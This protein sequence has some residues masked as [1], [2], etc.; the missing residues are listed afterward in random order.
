MFFSLV[1]VENEKFHILSGQSLTNE[2]N[3]I[4]RGLPLRGLEVVEDNTCVAVLL[5]NTCLDHF[6][7]NFLRE[8]LVVAGIDLRLLLSLGRWL[9]ALGFLGLL[10][11]FQSNLKFFLSLLKVLGGFISNR[12]STFH[13]EVEELIQF[14]NASLMLLREQ[15]GD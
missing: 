1:E 5:L 7:H 10:L 14:H 12:K 8:V 15:V 6:Y 3:D 11:L 9:L 13:T 4:F 2:A